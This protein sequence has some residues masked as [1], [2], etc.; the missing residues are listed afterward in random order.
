MS[1]VY[2]IHFAAP[3]APGHPCQHYIGYAE[4][5]AA[6]MKHHHK[7]TGARLT[8]VAVERGIS[9]QVVRVWNGDRG[10][11]RH[12]KNRKEAPHLC[13]LCDPQAYRREPAQ[14][15]PADEIK[16]LFYHPIWQG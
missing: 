1:Y 14:E 10:R 15:V 4:N 6:R 16:D 2:L 8:Q 13:P 9:F 7:G 5:L 11:E 12:I 3:T